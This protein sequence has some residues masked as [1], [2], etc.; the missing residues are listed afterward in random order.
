M[1]GRRNRRDNS[2][3][4]LV[5]LNVTGSIAKPRGRA[6]F[7]EIVD[8][9][10]ELAAAL[11]SFRFEV[12]LRYGEHLRVDLSDLGRPRLLRPFVHA[13]WRAFQIGGRAGSRSTASL[14]VKAVRLF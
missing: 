2:A 11:A 9:D 5:V 8:P 6:Q 13:L 1:L 14:Y 3:S 12:R 4:S 10:A 7:P